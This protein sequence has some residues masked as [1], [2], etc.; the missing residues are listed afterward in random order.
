VRF[1]LAAGEVVALTGSPGSGKSALMGLLA[2]VDRPDVGCVRWGGVDPWTLSPTER[3]SLR[4]STVAWVRAGSGAAPGLNTA[5]DVALLGPFGT[6]AFDALRAGHDHDTP[7]TGRRRAIARA[8]G[9]RPAALLLDDPT[10]G[11]PRADGL[12]LL[13]A[14]VALVRA[15][16]MG[17][18][19]A[20][21]ESRARDLADRSLRLVRGRFSGA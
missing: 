21:E 12:D 9:T 6:E 1:S 15:H 7:S 16:G 14:V 20:T 3:A 13:P 8:L 10:R 11:L 18:L 19:V 5:H 17:L 4:R 2:A